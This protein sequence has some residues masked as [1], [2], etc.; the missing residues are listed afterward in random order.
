MNNQKKHLDILA[1]LAKKE[2]NLLLENNLKS[3][4]FR[5]WLIFREFLEGRAKLGDTFLTLLPGHLRDKKRRLGWDNDLSAQIISRYIFNIF[6]DYSRELVSL[7]GYQV[8]YFRQG[9]DLNSQRL[10]FYVLTLLVETIIIADQYCAK[11]FIK[12][13]SV[14]IDAGAN[15]GIFSLYVSHL[16]PQGKIYSFEPTKDTFQVLNKNIISNNLE[17]RISVHNLA[18]GDK[19][20]ETELIIAQSDFLNLG[21]AIINN[22]IEPKTTSNQKQ[23]VKMITIDDF[24]KEN[25]ITKVD[26]V[27]I[28]TE[29][30]EKQIIKGASET[31][32]RFG[33]VIACSAYHLKDD[34]IKI[35]ELIMAINPSYNFKLE[36]RG[37]EDLIFWIDQ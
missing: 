18:L 20:G 10:S 30:Y 26:F 3:K 2:N 27:K 24:V 31:I 4:L 28:D 14:V 21:N 15:I 12:D 36:K 29:G 9:I 7:L 11:K 32:K 19:I 23:P 1:V 35:P 5:K 17:N 6:G 37:E 22:N 33:P 34:K 8:Y 16:A 13:D 25:K